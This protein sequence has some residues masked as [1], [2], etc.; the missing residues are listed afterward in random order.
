MDFAAIFQ[1]WV[2]VLTQ[3]NE[4]T[5]EAE[6]ESPNATLNCPDLDCGGG[7]GDG[8]PGLSPE[9]DLPGRRHVQYAAVHGHG[10]SAAGNGP[11]D[12]DVHKLAVPGAAL[13][14]AGGF[15]GI[16]L[17]PLFF[18]IGVGIFH[19]IAK[20]LGGQGQFDKYAYLIAALPGA[21]LDCHGCAGL[22]AGPGRLHWGVDLY[23]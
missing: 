2:R 13:S 1:T 22:R 17:A 20:L 7:S 15:L 3:P 11:D 16:I 4:Q 18:M 5:F 6:K 8:D 19:L 14:G 9:A 10:R 23:L 21:H 12:G